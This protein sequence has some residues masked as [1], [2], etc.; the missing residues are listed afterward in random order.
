LF[1]TIFR[2]ILAF[3]PGTASEKM[4]KQLIIIMGCGVLSLIFINIGYIQFACYFSAMIFG[5]ALSSI[6]AL[7]LTFSAIY[8]FTLADY[9]TGNI[10]ACGVLGEGFLTMFIG[11]LME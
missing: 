10:I 4:E 5:A 2:F 6:Y 1:V 8:G 7:I 3:L 9:Q 11:M